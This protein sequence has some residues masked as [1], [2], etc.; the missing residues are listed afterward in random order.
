MKRLIRAAF[1][2]FTF[3]GCTVTKPLHQ[4]CNEFRNGR[5][6]YNIYNESGLGHWRKLT[7]FIT[8]SDSLEIVTSTHLPKDTAINKI[9]WTGACG[10]KSLRLNPKSDLDS[11][12]IRQNP[13]GTRYTIVRATEAYFIVKNFGRKDTIW[14]SR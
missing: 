10:Y 2:T 8:L 4:T 14:R 6:T 13:T 5:Y 1:L 7:Y 11:F 3:Y 9:T 12:L